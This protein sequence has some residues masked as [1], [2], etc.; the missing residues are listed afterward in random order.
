MPNVPAE[1]LPREDSALQPSDATDLERVGPTP[2]E[3]GLIENPFESTDDNVNSSGS[4]AGE[5]G[6][7]S[8]PSGLPPST[9][10][11]GPSLRPQP[12]N[13]SLPQGGRFNPS[14]RNSLDELRGNRSAVTGE[15]SKSPEGIKNQNEEV[16]I[17][18]QLERHG[19]GRALQSIVQKTLKEQGESDG[20]QS[21]T[22]AKSADKNPNASAA[23]NK[24][25]DGAGQGATAGGIATKFNQQAPKNPTPNKPNPPSSKSVANNGNEAPRPSNGNSASSST[26]SGFRD[27][28]SQVWGAIRTAPGE[29]SGSASSKSGSSFGSGGY[30]FTWNGQTW[31]LL[32]LLGTAVVMLILLARKRIEQV[33]AAREAEAELAKEILTEGIRTRADVVRAFHRFVLRRAQPVANWW[34]HRYVASKLMEASPQLRTV[35]ADLA[36]VYEHARYLPPEV[37]LTSEEIDRVQAA[38]KQCVAANA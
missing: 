15:R 9:A 12:K 8:K 30:G 1:R 16:D 10:S 13:P 21:S 11:R 17:K 29:S 22:R 19:L 31:L 35:I 25:R 6:L 33:T 27:L 28:A 3:S 2:T 37:P 36:G 26:M 23:D 18:T 20:P 38:L 14:E 7:A 4:K 34:N 24:T 5:S 32:A